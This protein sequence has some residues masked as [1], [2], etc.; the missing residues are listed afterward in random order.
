MNWYQFISSDLALRGQFPH[1]APNLFGLDFL[2][3]KYLPGN[4]LLLTSITPALR[5]DLPSQWLKKGASRIELNLSV[6]ISSLSININQEYD[7]GLVI[8]I[9]IGPKN[10]RVLDAK[11][12]NNILIDADF[13]SIDVTAKPFFETDLLP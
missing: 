2:E 4:V 12:K 9:E 5:E 13:F 11:S 10:V 8:N 6:R 3:L 7:D 1:G